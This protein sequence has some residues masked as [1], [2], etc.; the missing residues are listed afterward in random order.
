MKTVYMDADGT[1]LFLDGIPCPICSERFYGDIYEDATGRYLALDI[2]CSHSP[3]KYSW[4]GSELVFEYQDDGT[5]D[6]E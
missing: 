4:D 1:K 3:Y 6:M 2:R 5:S